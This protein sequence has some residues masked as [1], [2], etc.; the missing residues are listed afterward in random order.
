MALSVL[1]I[2]IGIAIAVA[3]PIKVPYYTLSPG[4]V[5][6]TSDF[7]DVV[8]NDNAVGDSE[9]ELFFL[10]V[11]LQ[12]ANV[13]E[14]VAAQLSPRV[15]L[16]PRENIR[17]PGVSREDLRL[18]NLARMEQSKL[19]AQFV[20]L[21]ALG[22]E[23]TLIGTGAL[24]IETVSG[25]GADGVLLADDV[26]V[27]VD[28]AEVGFSD[29]LLDGLADKEIGDS[30]F[31]TVER[32]VEGAEDPEVIELEI[33]LGPHVDD[34]DRPMIGILLRDNDPIVEFPIE[35]DTDSRNIGGPSAGLMFTLEIINQLTEDD[36]TDGMRI[37]GTGTIR[38]DGT[39]GPIGG[40]KQKV[41]GAIDA[42]ATVV[43]IPAANYEDAL[44]A[45]GDDITVVRVETI[46]D[47][48]DYLNVD[49]VT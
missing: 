43:F 17:P 4:P 42:G 46:D 10:T 32:P 33:V 30:A 28:G 25:T 47:P 39:V 49:L 48:L 41:F 13:F 16:S 40:V 19:D 35:I 34:P 45:A 37:A 29:D 14:W 1:L 8:D 2:A 23:P 21:E 27:A 31:L 9:G 12:E 7:I 22:Y 18:E 20:A 38:R 6:D 5:Y 11:S 24:V 44:L 26:I 15:D 3:W 36:I